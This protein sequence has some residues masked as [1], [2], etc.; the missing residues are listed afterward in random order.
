MPQLACIL[1]TYI[2]QR[3]NT[4]GIPLLDVFPSD[5]LDSAYQDTFAGALPIGTS[6]LVNK[7]IERDGCKADISSGYIGISQ[8]GAFPKRD[9]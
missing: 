7:N 9:L 4:T 8:A 2:P 5:I 6:W 3:T 1:H